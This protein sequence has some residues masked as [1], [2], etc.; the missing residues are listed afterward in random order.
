M[1]MRL[2]TL[3]IRNFKGIK[4]YKLDPDGQSINILGDNG[5]GKTKR[6]LTGSRW[7]KTGTNSTI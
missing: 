5:T 4:E 7:T 3:T 6:H 1:K 2:N